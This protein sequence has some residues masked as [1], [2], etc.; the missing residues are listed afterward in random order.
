LPD[1]AVAANCEHDDFHRHFSGHDS[2]KTKKNQNVPFKGDLCFQIIRRNYHYG[3]AGSSIDLLLE[4]PLGIYP[5]R[6][7]P[8][9]GYN[10]PDYFCDWDSD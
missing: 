9:A 2:S 5:T 10:I 4:W 6:A 8:F 1:V 3:R 7:C